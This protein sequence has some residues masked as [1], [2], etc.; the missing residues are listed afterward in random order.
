M[1][2]SIHGLLYLSMDEAEDSVVK[3]IDTNVEEDAVEAYDLCNTVI[4]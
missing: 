2:V 3:M 1:E 4:V